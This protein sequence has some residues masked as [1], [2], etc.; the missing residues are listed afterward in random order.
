MPLYRGDGQTQDKS[1]VTSLLGGLNQAFEEVSSQVGPCSVCSVKLFVPHGHELLRPNSS[2][3]ALKDRASAPRHLILH[4]SLLLLN[5][6][7]N[8]LF[9]CFLPGWRDKRAEH[10]LGTEVIWW[11]LSYLHL[12]GR[13]WG[14]FICCN[15]TFTRRNGNSP[16]QPRGRLGSLYL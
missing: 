11:G 5:T 10:S 15:G 1:A 6:I 7:I 2:V 8:S 4:F 12:V 16:L 13:C 14:T 3:Q 9:P